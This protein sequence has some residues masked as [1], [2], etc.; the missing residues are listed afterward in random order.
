[1]SLFPKPFTP[2]LNEVILHVPDRQT[3]WYFH[4]PLEIIVV[5]RLDKISAALLE[6]ERQVTRL[7]HWAAGFLSYET[8]PAMDS[9]FQVN[10]PEG[11]S[12]FY[13]LGSTPSLPC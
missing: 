5:Y 7:G 1:M 3:W 6:V 12:R 9:A 4:D 2:L 13:G 10:Q 11:T 8:A